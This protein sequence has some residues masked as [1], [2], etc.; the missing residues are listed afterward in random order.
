ML[1]RLKNY[2]EN[3]LEKMIERRVNEINDQIKR[4]VYSYW[5]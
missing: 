1:E 4:G 2:L 3:Y 5:V